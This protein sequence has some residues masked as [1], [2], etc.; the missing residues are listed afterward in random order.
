M[1]AKQ[2]LLAVLLLLAVVLWSVNLCPAATISGT[3]TDDYHGTGVASA[4]V[5]V[6]GTGVTTYTDS[7]GAFTLTTTG[8]RQPVTNAA[9]EWNLPAYGR[10]T[11]YG[12]DG[13][14]LARGQNRDL[15]VLTAPLPEGM[16]LYTIRSEGLTCTGK[17][18]KAGAQ[19]QTGGLRP[20]AMAK[21]AANV[22]LVVSHNHYRTLE[23]TAAEGDGSVQVDLVQK[24]GWELNSTN[25]GLAGVGID[26]NS[27]PLY[28]GSHQ[29][30]KGTV[31]SLKKITQILYL[32]K[33]DITLDR[34]W[35]QPTS[36]TSLGSIVFTYNPEMS[37]PAQYHNKIIDCDIDGTAAN[38]GDCGGALCIYGMCAIRGGGYDALRCNIYGMGSGIC[39][40]GSGYG[41]NCRIEQ[42]YV[43]NLRG[44]GESHNESST[45]R[46]FD[47]TQC[48]FR[49]NRMES[50]TGHDSGA[51]FITPW[52][53]P[54]NH[55]SIEGNLFHTGNWCVYVGYRAYN[56]SYGNDMKLINNRFVLYGYGP[57]CCDTEGLTCW[58]VFSE[59]YYNNP[60][61]PPENMGPAI[62]P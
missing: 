61:L 35:I 44:G 25:T 36:G 23:Q 48:I 55:C 9:V 51:L 19:C 10:A 56:H 12:A 2:T 40:Y 1:S 62:M 29:P 58:L 13:T 42:N 7:T 60:N 26:K 52:Q 22:T 6:K 20:M 28:T 4:L 27:L 37:I 45:I 54:V 17:L 15:A 8:I 33:G 57:V 14:A 49:N 16:Y 32:E 39:V 30:A 3:V 38:Q 21:A 59:N 24:K 50:L 18:V 46:G 41:L 53:G 31:I 5:E 11:L 34:C 43:H 47:G